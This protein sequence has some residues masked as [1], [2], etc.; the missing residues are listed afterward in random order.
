MRS[1]VAKPDKRQ[2]QKRPAMRWPFNTSFGSTTWTRT[3]DPVINS[4]LLYQLSYRGMRAILLIKKEKSSDPGKNFKATAHPSVWLQD[5]LCQI[6]SG[7]PK[8]C[9]SAV[10][11]RASLESSLL[12]LGPRGRW[13]GSTQCIG[14]AMPRAE[15][16]PEHV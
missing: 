13:P 5:Q 1:C 3:R 14:V 7:P 8:A 12:R 4:H 2:A 15:F 11:K 6:A 10:R 9:L 16:H